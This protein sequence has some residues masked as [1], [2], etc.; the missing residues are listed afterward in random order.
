MWVRGISLRDSLDGFKE[1]T[2]L[3]PREAVGTAQGGGRGWRPRASFLFA[4]AFLL[5]LVA[6]IAFYAYGAVVVDFAYQ[7]EVGGHIRNAYEVNT[8]EAMIDELNRSVAGMHRLGLTDAMYSRY[9][10]WERTPDRSMAFQYEFLD[11]LINRTEAVILWRTLA[12]NGNT[13]PETLGDVYEQK[14]D[15]LRSFMTEGCDSAYVCTD[16]IAKDVYLLN[17]APVYFF[18]GY[19]VGGSTLVMVLAAP[20]AIITRVGENLLRLGRFGSG[21]RV[22][23]EVKRAITRWIVFPLFGLGV[24]L[25]ALPFVLSAFRP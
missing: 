19:F 23:P 8:P 24:V 6:A 11:Q 3:D 7:R 18:S 14:M 13:T 17:V 12:Y 9:F 22:P 2:R 21:G 15:N 25:M 16:W 20:A 10:P 4:L 5:A 1:R